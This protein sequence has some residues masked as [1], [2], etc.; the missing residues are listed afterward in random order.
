MELSA[1]HSAEVNSVPLLPW[2]CQKPLTRLDRKR[3]K[4]TGD[5]I[6][7]PYNEKL[8]ELQGTS[9]RQRRQ[10]QGNVRSAT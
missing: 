4:E 5:R 7:D 8:P 2:T 3:L 1:G 9:H 6:S 10:T